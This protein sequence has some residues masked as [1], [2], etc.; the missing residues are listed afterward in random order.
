MRCLTSS[1]HTGSL[2]WS[3]ACSPM[4]TIYVG[5]QGKK[6]SPRSCVHVVRSSWGPHYV[7]TENCDHICSH[8]PGRLR[9]Q[10]VSLEGSMQ[11]PWSRHLAGIQQAFSRPCSLHVQ[12]F[13]HY[14]QPLSYAAKPLFLQWED[15]SVC[16]CN[17]W[18]WWGA[19]PRPRG[20]GADRNT[21]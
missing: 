11:A 2:F 6:L 12:H 13:C 3:T 8:W 1:L 7:D 17:L 4:T 10:K 16:Q 19:W 5:A 14:V 21:G 15:C 9:V 20:P 18:Y